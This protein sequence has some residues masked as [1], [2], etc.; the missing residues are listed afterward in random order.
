M[1]IISWLVCKYI[2]AIKPVSNMIQT[3]FNPGK[4]TLHALLTI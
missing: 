4:A 3:E 2:V 1:E